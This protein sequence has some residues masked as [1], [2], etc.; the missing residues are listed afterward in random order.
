MSLAEEGKQKTKASRTP[1]QK[2]WGG[3]KGPDPKRL[4]SQTRLRP[5]LEHR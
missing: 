5:R 3:L 4:W 2:D 1:N